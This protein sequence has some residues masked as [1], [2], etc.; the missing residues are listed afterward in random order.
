MRWVERKVQVKMWRESLE[1]T[2]S[3]CMAIR[4]QVSMAEA[5]GNRDSWKNIFIF[6]GIVVCVLTV[7]I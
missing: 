1:T 5:E 7:L 4:Q 2:V 6:M 3:K